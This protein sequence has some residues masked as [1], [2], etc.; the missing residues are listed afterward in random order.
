MNAHATLGP[1]LRHRR[2]LSR[3]RAALAGGRLRLGF[4]GGSITAPKTG[5]RWPEPLVGWIGQRFPAARLMVENAA[6][7]ATGSD[8]GVFR[9]QPEIVARECDLVFVEYAVNDFGQP[10]A[11]RNRTREGLLRQLLAAGSDVVLVYTY[12]PE[13]LPDMVAGRVPLSIAEFEALADHYGIGSVWMGLHSWQEVGRGLMTWAE[14][15]PDG[16]HPENR[17]SLSYAQSVMAFCEAEW[18]TALAAPAWMNRPALPGVLHE[19]CW[20]RVSLLP[21]EAAQCTGPWSLRRWFTCLGMSQ[22]LH[23]TVPGAVLK[24]AFE[25]RGLMLGF[26]FGRLAGEVSYRVDGGSWQDTQRDRPAWAGDSGWFRPTVVTDALPAAAH[27]LELKTLA[28]PVPGGCGS[29]TT[30]GLIGVIH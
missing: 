30:L 27:E 17:G 7:G 9:V 2:G 1:V 18:G 24:I 8:L 25:G 15:L 29:V 21:L 22:A 12:C 16:L 14:W 6:L 3:S 11:R 23:T 13:M 26:D 5:T 10:T 20:D 4:I 19:G 28:V